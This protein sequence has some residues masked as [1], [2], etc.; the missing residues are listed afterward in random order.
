M[1]SAEFYSGEKTAIKETLASLE[2]LEN[3][4]NKAYE[5]WEFLEALATELTKNQ[6]KGID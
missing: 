4:L 6:D 5:R 3:A 2:A 1:S